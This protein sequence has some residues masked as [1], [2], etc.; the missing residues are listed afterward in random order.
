MNEPEEAC[1]VC[2][3]TEPGSPASGRGADKAWL[4]A[5]CVEDRQVYMDRNNGTSLDSI[6]WA[7]R[8][9]RSK[10]VEE[11]R[12]KALEEAASLVASYCIPGDSLETDQPCGLCDWCDAAG[13]I[14]ARRSG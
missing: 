6:A 12:K 8:K 5:A 13:E 14:L 4:C 11:A 2:G 9:S 10:A 1:V 7:A 3:C